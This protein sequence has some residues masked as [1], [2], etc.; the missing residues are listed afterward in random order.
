M[1][2]RKLYR[3]SRDQLFDYLRIIHLNLVRYWVVERQSRP[4][5]LSDRSAMVFAPHQDD[6]VLGC[7]G[8]IALK[9]LQNTPVRVVFVT[10]GK[11]FHGDYSPYQQSEAVSNRKLEAIAALSTLGLAPTEIDFLDQPDGELQQLSEVQKQ[12][13]IEQIVGLL[14]TYQ[15][16]TV[17]VP[18]AQDAHPDHEATYT[19]VKAA[20]ALRDRN[21]TSQPIELW[22][23][24]IWI[25]WL[26]V[27]FWNLKLRSIWCS[28]HLD[29]KSVQSQKIA[30]ISLYKSQHQ[31]L[32]LAFLKQFYLPYE[33]YFKDDQ[34]VGIA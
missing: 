19:L 27:L 33:I 13:L 1:Q 28:Y 14:Q 16:Q 22:Q 30:A 34:E 21:S 15:P 8:L 12:D 3:R 29:I 5:S 11:A 23:Y 25:F 2:I 31:V 4:F 32:P 7:G 18:H 20:I 9:C 24:P 6:E 17:Y 26:R 10:D